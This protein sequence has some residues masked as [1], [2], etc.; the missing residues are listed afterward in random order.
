MDVS[1][2]SNEIFLYTGGYP[3]LVSRICQHIDEKLSKNWTI[4]GVRQAVNILLNEKNMLFDDIRK[5]LENNPDLY[6]FVYDIL[7]VGESKSFQIDN[8]LIDLGY[9]FGLFRDVDGKVAISNRIFSQRIYSYFISIDESNS[10]RKHITGV[11]QYDVVK[12]GLFD[13]ELCLRKF[14]SHYRE[15]FSKQDFEFLERHGRL[16]TVKNKL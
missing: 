6:N 7:I 11:L 1:S 4:D 3:Y 2:V 14:A 16:I 12:D 13:M 15:M 8:P 10:K 5:N 9:T